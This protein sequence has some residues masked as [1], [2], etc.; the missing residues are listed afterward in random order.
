MAARALIAL[1]SA[2]VVPGLVFADAP[3]AVTVTRATGAL[4][5]DGHL[6]ESAWQS[7]RM[8]DCFVQRDPVE[9]GQPSERT[10]VRLLYDSE[11]LYVGAMLFDSAPD[12]I[13]A[14]AARRDVPTRS[15][16]FTIF[17]DPLS[18]GRNGY[19][20]RVTAAGTQV[21]ALLHN[22][23]QNDRSWDGAWTARTARAPGGW[24]V[25]M[26]IPFTDMRYDESGR[27]RINM[28]REIARRAEADFLVFTPRKETGFVSRFLELSGL[29]RIP[30]RGRWDVS[31]YL[32]T[33][34]ER[35]LAAA[36]DPF[37]DGSATSTTGGVDVRRALGS[38]MTLSAAIHPDFGQVEVDP[39]VVNLTDLE[40]FFPEKRPFFVEA[41][42]SYE[43]GLTGPAE[44]PQFGWTHPLLFY[45]RRIGRAPH[46]AVSAS[47]YSDVPDG[48]AILAAVR[49]SGKPRKTISLAAMHAVT[50][51]ER[52][53]LSS[54]GATSYQDV[55]PLT[56][57]GALRVRNDAADGNRGA[58]LLG[59]L[60]SRRLL[61][62]DMRRQLAS[63]AL[64]VGA[65]AWSFLGE[66]RAWVVSGWGAVSRIA[67]DSASLISLQRSSAHY[68][69]RPDAA[70]TGVD[71]SATAFAGS[72]ARL[73]VSKE[74]GNVVFNAAV[75][76]IGPRF[77]PNDIGFLTRAD[78]VNA[79]V[80]AGY[81]WTDPGRVAR[82]A[83]VSATAHHSR[84]HD[85]NHTATGYR[86][87][88]AAQTLGYWDASA[89]IEYQPQSVDVRKTRGGPRVIRPASWEGDAASSSDSR[90][91]LVVSVRL[92]GSR[93]AENTWLLSTT[94]GFDWRPWPASLLSV[95]PAVV[96]SRQDAQYV[97]SNAD[98][99][100]TGTY[101]RR[102]VF[103]TLT[104]TQ[105]QTAIRAEWTFTPA[106]SF[107]LFAQPL[108]SVNA[109]TDFKE[110]RRA[111]SY[112]FLV[113]GTEGSTIDL[114]SGK[115]DPDGPGPAASFRLTDP[116][117]NLVSLRGTAVLRWEYAPGSELFFVWTQ[118]R[119]NT[120][121][122]ESLDVG[123][124][125]D[126]LGGTAPRN[127]FLV[128]ATYR[129][130]L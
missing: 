89:W 53:R 77:E 72:A 70:H 115:V 106:V 51:R 121:S 27:W 60:A 78:V 5:V 8:V 118:D 39:A 116:D 55:E 111:N 14:R 62:P 61:V 26:R 76:A 54:G 6:D 97:Q 18:D 94:L 117:A 35:A 47:T 68:L 25:E 91:A 30:A 80:Q 112:D 32:S 73:L 105:L 104:Q 90:K 120:E 95:R 45:S 49:A 122:S 71:S 37:H 31:P 23:N 130:S 34:Q 11:A 22:D 82:S 50:E 43:F 119:S 88:A 4:R 86:T 96:R 9:G 66:S 57:Y 98:R 99:F 7:V 67:G 93:D 123:D 38:R 75:G 19:M 10:E 107:Q 17:L 16:G 128:K 109:F 74:R 24:S 92:H 102:Y 48:A 15:D 113:Y 20:F 81:R 69:Q 52:A 41:A 33:K 58:G 101:G 127:V 56:Y 42:S 65:D 29:R 125:F 103:A 46:G 1:L 126:R 12:S 40:T 84:D 114:A 63:S 28:R 124:S 36:S 129:L 79:H 110:L 87:T 13:V 85:W 108:F 59:T 21:D 44:A 3:P 2:V 64:V 83:L 100:A